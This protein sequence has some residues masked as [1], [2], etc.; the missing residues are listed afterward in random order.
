M[1]WFRK[2]KVHEGFERQSIPGLVVFKSRDASAFVL[3][4]SS[5]GNVCSSENVLGLIGM[6]SFESSF[7]ALGS[8]EGNN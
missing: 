5:W 4:S 2:G 6:T 1:I 3:A 8:W 7:G